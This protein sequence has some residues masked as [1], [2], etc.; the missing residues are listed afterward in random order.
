M[1]TYFQELS[2][3]YTFILIKKKKKSISIIFELFFYYIPPISRKSSHQPNPVYTRRI[4]IILFPSYLIKT[5]K[6]K[7]IYLLHFPYI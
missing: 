7:S 3:F 5:K 6:K 2:Q 4:L 1:L